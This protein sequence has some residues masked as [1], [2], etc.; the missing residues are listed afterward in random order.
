MGWKK[1]QLK[2]WLKGLVEWVDKKDQLNGLTKTTSWMSWQK[3]PGEWDHKKD[4]SN[5]LWQFCLESGWEVWPVRTMIILLPLPLISQ[6][7]FA[8]SQETR[9]HWS[10]QSRWSSDVFQTKKGNDDIVLVNPQKYTSNQ[11]ECNLCF[12]ILG[13]SYLDICPHFLTHPSYMRLWEVKSKEG[14]CKFSA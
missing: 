13:S 6:S 4:Q 10:A 3:W 5:G 14:K 1:V 11:I 2:C 7:L 12:V 9:K 8:W